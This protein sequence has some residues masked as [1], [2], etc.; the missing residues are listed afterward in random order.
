MWGFLYLIEWNFKWPHEKPKQ[1]NAQ[2][3][4]QF[5]HKNSGF[6]CIR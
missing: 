2:N 1:T 6:S 3:K 4:T 5:D